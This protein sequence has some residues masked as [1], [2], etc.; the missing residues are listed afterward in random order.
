MVVL[1]ASTML[2]LAQLA[3]GGL[4][5]F[6][7]PMFLVMVGLGI[8]LPNGPAVALHRHGEAA[9]TAAALL[10]ASQFVMAAL[11]TPVVGALEDGTSRPIPMVI[12]TCSVLALA[13]MLAAGPRLRADSYD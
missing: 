2:L 7:M 11:V 13:L 8:C 3:S 12:L 10:G 5:G 6:L 9:G 4:L 1:G